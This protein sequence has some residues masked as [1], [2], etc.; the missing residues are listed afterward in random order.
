MAADL[1]VFDDITVSDTSTFEHPH[2]YLKGF[3]Y[4]IVNGAIT[5]AKGSHTGIWNGRILKGARAVM[6]Y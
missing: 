1:V 5:V 4:V 2:A 6:V 3:E